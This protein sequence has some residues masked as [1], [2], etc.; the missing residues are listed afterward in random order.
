MTPSKIG[1]VHGFDNLDKDGDALYTKTT[2]YSKMGDQTQEKAVSENAISEDE[3]TLMFMVSYRDEGL[4][5]NE[6]DWAL[7]SDMTAGLEALSGFTRRLSAIV[8][9]EA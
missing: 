2:I 5:K 4:K 7:W 1:A 6:P 9:C 3:K 8:V